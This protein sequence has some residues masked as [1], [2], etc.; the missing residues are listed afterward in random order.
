MLKERKHK[1]IALEEGKILPKVSWN[2]LKG[3]KSAK[4]EGNR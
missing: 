1:C 4:E 3:P 2:L